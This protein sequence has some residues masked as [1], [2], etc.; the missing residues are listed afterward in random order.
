MKFKYIGLVVASALLFTACESEDDTLSDPII[1]DTVSTPTTPTYTS[2]SADFS[3]FVSV[4]NSLT[5]GYSDGTVFQRGQAASFPNILAQRFAL[6]GGGDFTQPLV[7]DDIGGLLFG[8]TP[9]TGPRLIFDTVNQSPVPVSGTPTTE[10]TNIIPGPFNNMGVPGAKSFHL[11]APGYGNAMN[12]PAAA[13]PYFIRMASSPDVSVIADAM[14]Q[15]PTFFSLWIGNNDVLGYATS[16]GDG[17]NPITDQATFDFALGTL[18]QTLVSGGAE[19]IIA[20]IPSVTDAPYFTTVPFAPLS[21]AN[22]DFGPLIPQLNGIFGQLNQVYAFLESQG[23]PNATD[24]QIVFSE[25][26]ASAAV[27][28]DESLANLSAQISGVLNASPTFPSFV[29]SLGLPAA[30]APLVANLLGTAYGQS[31]QANAN[32]LIVLPSSSVIGTVNEPFFN[33]LLSQNIPPSLA[34]QFS[35]EGVTYPLDDKWVL[36]P[37]EI[38]EV[39]NAT[40]G[41]NATIDALATQY[42]LAFFDVNTFF[43]QVATSGYQAGSAFMTADYVTG[44]T[45]SLDGVHPSPRGY[46]VV[47]NQMIDLINAKYGSNIPNVNPVDFTGLYIN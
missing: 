38:E 27:I 20:N 26:A 21:P 44:G 2:G 13:N 35:V 40:A 47:S 11:L 6:A 3:T 18:A 34:G 25:T 42:D 1:D 31:R 5:A 41:F 39:T 36:I 22:P 43:N 4:G 16:G 10:V 45:F 7:S 9:I 17:S 28:K 14:A 24:R 8:G 15:S 46:A 19:G 23:V 37:S 32:D 29:E 12:F 33:F 30:A